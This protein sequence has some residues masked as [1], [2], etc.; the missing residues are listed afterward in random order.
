MRPP[1]AFVALV[2]AAGLL[3]GCGSGSPSVVR[4][5]STTPTGSAPTS[6]APTSTAPTS[7][8]PTSTAPVGPQ[9]VSVTPSR[10]LRDG[11]RV[12][13]RASGFSPDEALQVIQCAAKGTAT[14]PGDC[15]LSGMLSVTSDAS[16]AVSATLQ[17]VRGPFGAN[18]VLCTAATPCLISVTQASLS[19]TEE[20]DAPISFAAA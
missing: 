12:R 10:G 15:N 3:A 9:R 20:A 13:V 11:Q 16:G 14:G 19:P 18:N 17:V 5:G 1:R 6:T 8:A 2:C 4:P 7:T